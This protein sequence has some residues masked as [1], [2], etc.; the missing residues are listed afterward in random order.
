MNSNKTTFSHRN[1]VNLFTSYELDTCSRDL[2]QSL[3]LVITFRAVKLTKNT[4]P[5]KYG[6]SGY[7]IGFD[8]R[9]QF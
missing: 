6:H 3:H 1:A 8:A 7:G 2:V 9:S 5:N 4:D